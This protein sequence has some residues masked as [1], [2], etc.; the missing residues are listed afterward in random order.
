MNIKLLTEHHL[1]FISLEGGCTGLS[2]SIHVK[3]PHCWKSHVVAHLP[4]AGSTMRVPSSAP[5]IDARLYTLRIK[6]GT[7]QR[8]L[9]ELSHC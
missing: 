8:A 7:N 5:C 1:E 3:I 6:I 4:E 9:G 2:E